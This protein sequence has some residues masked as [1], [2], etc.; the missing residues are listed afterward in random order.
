[1]TTDTTT[2]FKIAIG[3][4]ARADVVPAITYACVEGATIKDIVRFQVPYL[5]RYKGAPSEVYLSVGHCD[6]VQATL[7]K[8]RNKYEE[9]EFFMGP[10]VRE[11]TD[12]ILE[13]RGKNA[14]VII[15][16]LREPIDYTPVCAG[17]RPLAPYYEQGVKIL[18]NYITGWGSKLNFVEIANVK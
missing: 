11:F 16:P 8:H 14:S 4:N 18:N 2:K 13:L 12:L 10:V 9:F 1:M 17:L 7:K 6:V 3:D 5:N 15:Y